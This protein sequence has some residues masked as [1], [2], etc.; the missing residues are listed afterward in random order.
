MTIEKEGVME[1]KHEE[2]IRSRQQGLEAWGKYKKQ[3]E[4]A[5]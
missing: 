4:K 1:R 3:G 2:D 5:L